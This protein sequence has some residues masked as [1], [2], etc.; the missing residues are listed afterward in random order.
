[1]LRFGIVDAEPVFA[2]LQPDGRLI[3]Y[4]AAAALPSGRID[5]AAV[6][7]LRY[8]LRRPSTTSA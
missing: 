1:M 3:S 6:V 2:L 5:D 8:R 4:Q 7:P